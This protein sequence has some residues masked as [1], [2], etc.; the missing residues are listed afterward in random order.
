[1]PEKILKQ[2]VFH[3]ARCDTDHEG[4]EFKQFNGNL[5]TD[6]DGTWDWWGICPVTGDPIL[7]RILDEHGELVDPTTPGLQPTKG[8][9][10]ESL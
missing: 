10:D 9:I 3:C 6:S 8:I 7:L 5:I 4:L 2:S 1:M